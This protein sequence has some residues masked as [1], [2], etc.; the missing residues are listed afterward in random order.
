MITGAYILNLI[1]MLALV[2][3]LA[4]GAL[5]LARKLQPGLGGQ[6]REGAVRVVDAVAMG[7][8]GRLAVVEFAGKQLLLAVSRGRIE[9]IAEAPIEAAPGTAFADYIDDGD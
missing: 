1:L 8:T 2:A 3:G 7:A 4:V 6:R 5:W 9:L